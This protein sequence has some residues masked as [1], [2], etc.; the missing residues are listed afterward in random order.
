[1]AHRQSFFHVFTKAP[2]SF[3][4]HAYFVCVGCDLAVQFR[5]GGIRLERAIYLTR[6]LFC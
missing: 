2:F 4:F 6:A 3:V 5:R 1:M